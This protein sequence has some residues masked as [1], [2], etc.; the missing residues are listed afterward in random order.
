MDVQRRGRSAWR[1]PAGAV[2]A[3]MLAL[4]FALAG[5]A[6]VLTGAASA[7]SVLSVP[8]SYPTIQ[9]AIDAASPGDTVSVAPGTYNERINNNDKA[10]TIESTGGA[11]VTTINGGGAGSV[12]LLGANAGETPVVRGFT[13]TNGYSMFDSGG[14]ATSG[15][16]ALIENN[17]IT[18]NKNCAGAGAGVEAAFSAATIRGN[19]ISNNGPQG[20]SGGTGGGG[21]LVRGA[22]TVKILGNVITGNS[23]AA[24]S[25]G[26]ITLFAAGAPTVSGNTI[27]GN[28]NGGAIWLANQSDALI[29]NNVITG[30]AGGGVDSSSAPT[31]VN[32]TIAVNSGG[33]QFQGSGVLKN[34]VLVGLGNQAVVSCSSQPA[35]S[36]NDVWSAGGGAGYSGCSDQTGFNGNIRPTRSSWIRSGTTTWAAARPRSMR[37]PA[38]ARPRS[39]A[40]ERRDRSTGTAIPRRWSTW[41]HT[42]AASRARLPGR[43]RRALRRCSGPRLRPPARRSPSTWSGQPRRP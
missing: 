20:C 29:Q 4:T 19:T 22:G 11:A 8:Q 37:A 1:V 39:I 16:P 42:S 26:G 30:N 15:G 12:V 40:T 24:G 38:Q 36:F 33:P 2:A 25:G 34:N 28:L 35:L 41:A 21:I 3:A 14:V 18:G 17:V 23:T 31:L 9:A 27:S 43:M 10:I 6:A 13:L 7:G 32:N 5:D